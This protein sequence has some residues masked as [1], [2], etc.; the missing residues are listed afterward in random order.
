MEWDSAVSEV[1]PHVVKIETPQGHGTGF[2]FIVSEETN[3]LGIATARHVIEHADKWQTPIRLRN[4]S[5]NT[6]QLYKEEDR[7]IVMDPRR[8]K[9]LAVILIR[10]G[11]LDLPSSPIK[12][13]P[14]DV[15]LLVGSEVGWIGYPARFGLCF[16]SGRIS[17]R[18]GTFGSHDFAYL[19]DG[20]AINGVSGGPVI[21]RHEDHEPRI[22]GS[23]TAYY[24]NRA[25]GEALPGLSLAQDV[26]S[27]HMVTQAIRSLE[28]SHR[29][30]D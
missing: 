25:T 5:N 24:P 21:V 4:Q 10:Q 19:I 6:T 3:Y 13:L 30:G 23:I 29:T 7:V 20:V 2:L 27:L 11:S 17:G 16:F 1:K 8:D 14:P 26:S 9:D 12:L 15:S 22:V 28:E 18:M